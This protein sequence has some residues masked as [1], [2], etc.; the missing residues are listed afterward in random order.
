M[1][2]LNQNLKSLISYHHIFA[3]L[4]NHLADGLAAV[5]PTND[6]NELFFEARQVVIAILNH[7]SK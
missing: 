2:S 7:I 5:M 3:R 1:I 4:H 6:Q